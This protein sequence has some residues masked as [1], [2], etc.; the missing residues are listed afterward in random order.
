[1]YDNVCKINNYCNHKCSD[2]TLVS[3]ERPS[4]IAIAPSA[5]MSLSL[6]NTNKKKIRWM[7]DWMNEKI[8]AKRN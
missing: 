3:L 4:P 7:I 1:M 8:I 2:V 5:F 6:L